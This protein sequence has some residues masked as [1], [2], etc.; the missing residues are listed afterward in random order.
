MIIIKISRDFI[1]I[2]NTDDFPSK[3]TQL[4]N[5]N[6]QVITDTPVFTS[7]INKVH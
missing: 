3:G 4:V 1:Q 2:T 7:I 5:I 6:S